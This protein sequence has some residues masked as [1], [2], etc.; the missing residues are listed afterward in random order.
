MFSSNLQ[1]ALTAVLLTAS[2]VLFGEIPPQ[3]FQMMPPMDQIYHPV[4][5]SNPEVQR[6]FDQGLTY[7]F[8]FNHDFAFRNFEEASNI[9]PNLA[10]AYWG[11]AMALGQ[12]INTDVT[13][14]NEIKA[15][16]YIQKALKL[17]P[18]A[19]PYEQDYINALA[20]RYTNDSSADLVSLRFKYRDAMKNVVQKYSE[21]LDAKTLYAESI[22]D[23]DPWNWWTRDGKPIGDI[24]EALDILE[25]VLKRN[26]QHIGANHYII[27]ALEESPYFDR[28]LLPAYRLT[29]LLPQ[30]GHLLHM[31]TH[32]FVLTGDYESA[33]RT[34]LKAIAQ[35]RLYIDR[36][37]V[38]SGPYPMHYLTHNLSVMARIY[39][40]MNDYNK[41]IKAA[42]ELTQFVGPNLNDVE[43][44][45][46]NANVPLEIYLYFHKWEEILS[47]PLISDVAS[48]KAFWHFSRAMAYAALG[49]VESA[50]K[51]KE[52]MQ[53]SIQ[54]IEPSE[55]IAS[56]PAT[57]VFKLAATL[58]DAKIE[59]AQGNIEQSL[60]LLRDAVSIDDKLNYDEPPAWS[61][62]V[63]QILGFALLKQER[64]KEAEE[65]F[66]K[67]SKRLMRN[68]RNLFGLMLSLKGQNRLVDAYWAEREMAAAL[69][70]SPHKLRL[71]DL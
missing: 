60:S 5:T 40:L 61:T 51:E 22:L 41:A 63:S 53:Q 66:Q 65:Q 3:A 48:S 2:V 44:G 15:Y 14:E 13:P 35:D 6:K 67:A 25:E 71:E 9:D 18:Q 24:Y 69:R 42:Y 68:G 47:H 7:L 29:E 57:D 45:A 30:A 56:N 39:L 55:K 64:F 59:E 4:S 12:N 17:A 31:P 62:P 70:H 8:A 32:I 1:H 33:L 19:S 38:F 28:A 27:H 20:V 21:D 46:H 26:P 23:L 10:M 34:N 58:L 36:F 54:K 11:M 16:N 37:G 52:L 49:K 43:H 50:K